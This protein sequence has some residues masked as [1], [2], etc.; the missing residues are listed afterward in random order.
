MKKVNLNGKL[1]LKKEIIAKLN[2]EQMKTI[3][4]K[5]TGSACPSYPCNGPTS[6]Q[7]QTY[8]GHASCYTNC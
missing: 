2:N 6:M 5:G 1:S 4:G 3:I 7:C 8:P